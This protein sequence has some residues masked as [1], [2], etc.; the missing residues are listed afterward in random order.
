[1]ITFGRGK[2]KVWLSHQRIGEDHVFFLGGGER[3]HVG[4]VV[5]AQPGKEPQ[6]ILLEGHRDDVVLLPIAKLACEKYGTAVVV[7]GGVH[8]ENASKEDI[9]RLV[10]N[11]RHLLKEM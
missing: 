10:E 3:A 7:V 8:V 5:I 11:C 4:S 6:V 9:G 1:M 2:F